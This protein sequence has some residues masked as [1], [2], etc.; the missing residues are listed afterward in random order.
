MLETL[1]A[2]HA[3]EQMLDDKLENEEADDAEDATEGV[4][5]AEDRVLAEAAERRPDALDDGVG[6][7]GAQALQSRVALESQD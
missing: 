6:G 2:D 3:L 7:V 4:E 1:I 5:G